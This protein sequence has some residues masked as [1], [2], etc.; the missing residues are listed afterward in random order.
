MHDLYLTQKSG[1]YFHFQFYESTT[2]LCQSKIVQIFFKRMECKNSLL[3]SRKNLTKTLDASSEKLFK[4]FVLSWNICKKTIKKL[5]TFFFSFSEGPRIFCHLSLCG[6]SLAFPTTALP[7]PSLHLTVC[8]F[9]E[10]DFQQPAVKK[11]DPNGRY[12]H[13]ECSK[14]FKWNLYFHGS[15]QSELFW[16]ELKLL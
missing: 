14:Q 16:A 9:D 8:P 15:G 2:F 7:K 13:I 4:P 12:I 6:F 10:L 1:T 3:K 11:F 5:S